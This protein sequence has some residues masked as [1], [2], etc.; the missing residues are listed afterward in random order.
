MREPNTKWFFQPRPAGNRARSYDED[1]EPGLTSLP[2]AMLL[3]HG[4][5]VLDPGTAVA[6]DRYP[7]PQSTVYRAKTLLVPGNMQ[8]KEPIQA[9][10]RILGHIG[11][12]LVPSAPRRGR[13][14][15]NGNRIDVLPR[16][17]RPAMLVPAK[18]GDMP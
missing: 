9:L 11:V 1:A 10:N 15:G 2:A 18:G 12:H 13:H 16:L 6:V 8:G 5:R 17:P 4:A 14:D 7:P 3:R